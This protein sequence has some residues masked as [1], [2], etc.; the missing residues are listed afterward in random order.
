MKIEDILVETRQNGFCVIENF[1]PESIQKS[2]ML[3]IEKRFEYQSFNGT[4]G[5]CSTNKQKYLQNALTIKKEIL[6]IYLSDFILDVYEKYN[7][8]PVILEHFRIYQNLEGLEM[9]WHIDNKFTK[10]DGTSEMNN[11]EGLIMLIYLDDCKH[12]N[13]Q[14]V[15][16]S[17]KWSNKKNKEFWDDE[18]DFLKEDVVTINNPGKG[19]LI[20]FDYR[21]IHRAE[22]FSKG[23]PRTA[24]FA[25]YSK[26]NMK[27]GEPIIIDTSFLCDLNERKMR[28]LR[29]G[30]QPSSKTWP[31]PHDFKQKAP[32]ET[33]SL[34][35]IKHGFLTLFS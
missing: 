26:E 25:Q 31:I 29:F 24:L 5:Y 17:H 23:S 4:I 20:F 7:Q 2:I 6:D 27:S 19:S 1:L 33:R 16:G 9:P 10:L 12:G 32:K 8:G 11:S 35:A 3:E 14:I 13:F 22:P 21:A 28:V 30:R 34:K 15:K 18:I